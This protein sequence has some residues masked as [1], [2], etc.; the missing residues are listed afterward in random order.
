[1]SIASRRIETCSDIGSS[2]FSVLGRRF[3]K[4]AVIVALGGIIALAGC[5]TPQSGR[6]FVLAPA[7]S[8]SKVQ[9][10]VVKAVLG[11][12]PISFPSH[13]DR[14]Q[15]VLRT[16]QNE[17]YLRENDKWAEPLRETARRVLMQDLQDRLAPKRMEAF[18]WNSR[19]GV[20]WQIA[21]DVSNFEAQPD[22]TVRLNAQWKI[23]DASSG[24]IVLS[25]Q[26]DQRIKPASADSADIVA[27]MSV[28]WG[29]FA[30]NISTAFTRS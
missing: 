23:I 16:G 20:D 18:P 22:R 1:M 13:L 15:L 24:E 14:A 27:A 21:V 17:L 5:T 8:Q 28:L 11:V 9:S 3:K 7:A 10:G 19:D 6:Y 30:D 29:R 4:G 25:N 12:G 2:R 26:F